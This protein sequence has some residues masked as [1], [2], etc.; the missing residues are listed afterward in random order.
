M[1]QTIIDVQNHHRFSAVAIISFFCNSSFKMVIFSGF[2]ILLTKSN[3]VCIFVFIVS[4]LLLDIRVCMFL[5][6]GLFVNIQSSSG[7]FAPDS[8]SI[9]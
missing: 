5:N 8:F 3:A 4:I 2:L 6:C 1:N 9:Q 7:F